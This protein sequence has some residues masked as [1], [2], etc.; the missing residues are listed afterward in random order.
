ML[1]TQP[2]F[3]FSP[4]L[5]PQQMRYCRLHF[6]RTQFKDSKLSFF[7]PPSFLP[8]LLSFLLLLLFPLL[9]CDECMWHSGKVPMKRP[10]QDASVCYSRSCF[11][12]TVSLSVSETHSFAQSG[13]LA[14]SW[15][16]PVSAPK[17]WVPGIWSH[18]QLSHGCWSFRLWSFC[19][20]CICSSPSS[21]L[22]SA[23]GACFP[24][25]EGQLAGKA[26]RQCLTV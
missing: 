20:Q 26:L 21:H 22:P 17:R 11:L 14:S 8:S 4:G 19:W 2:A 1:G 12:E 6:K 13:Y 10:E 25:A 7:L 24:V 15:D 18:V 23:F 9:M 16:A 5:D 3:S